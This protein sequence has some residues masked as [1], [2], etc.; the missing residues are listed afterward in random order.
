MFITT[1]KKPLYRELYNF[2]KNVLALT[3]NILF[4]TIIILKKIL[5]CGDIFGEEVVKVGKGQL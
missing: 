1:L 5:T 4:L 2:Q 3:D